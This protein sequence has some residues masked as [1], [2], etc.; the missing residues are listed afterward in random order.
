MYFEAVEG[1]GGGGGGDNNG[2]NGG[3]EQCE[4]G[5]QFNKRAA[6]AGERYRQRALVR[7]Q[8]YQERWRAKRDLESG[9]SV[10][11]PIK[12]RAAD[13]WFKKF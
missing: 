7:K 13:K 3:D 6:I 5:N 10:R 2:G 4:D 12:A 9:L 8:E 1:G 11:A